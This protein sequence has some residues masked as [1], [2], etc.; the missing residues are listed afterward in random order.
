MPGIG[1]SALYRADGTPLWALDPATGLH[2]IRSFRELAAPG[3]L[4]RDPDFDDGVRATK[5][6]A[7][8]VPGLTRLLGGYRDLRT[9]LF[10][11]LDLVAGETYTEFPYD[12]RR[13][14]AHNALLLERHVRDRLIRLRGRYP[15]AEVVLVAH[16]MGGLVA[17]EFLERHDQHRSVRAL[18]TL[19]TPFRGAVKAL[20]F[21]V[22]GPRVAHVRFSSLA[23]EFARLP[24]LYELLPVYPFIRLGTSPDS[25]L[26]GTKD[27]LHLLPHGGDKHA[28]EAAK[29]LDRLNESPE[30][31]VTRSFVG[32]GAPTLQQAVL[33]GSR[34]TVMRGS[35]LLPAS[36]RTVDGDGTVPLLSASPRS[37]EAKRLGSTPQNQTHSGL[38]TGRDALKALVIQISDLV[39]E[40]KI[41]DRGRPTIARTDCVGDTDMHPEASTLD[42]GSALSLDV[43]DWY[44]ADEP[45]NIPGRAPGHVGSTLW[46]RL[47]GHDPTELPV[48]DDGTFTITPG[49]QAEGVQRLDLLTAP[50]GD[51]LLT[52]V[53]EAA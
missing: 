33:S 7:L 4:L 38:V 9:T 44:D 13:P 19:G 35:H 37:S 40:G 24:A 46:Y 14:A 5:L 31:T 47:G 25:R 52:D 12:W 29:F 30:P 18:I 28:T 43:R 8:P 23:E 48:D 53:I 3:H 26:G 10:Q 39:R 21:L 45:V 15:N 32:F 16:S 11:H 22:N 1:G 49:P 41:L 20:D 2:P 17:R 34:L 6:M 50:E 51:V 36:H 42:T 27:V